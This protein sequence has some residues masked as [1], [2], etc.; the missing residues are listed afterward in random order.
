VSCG[1]EE[2]SWDRNA[3]WEGIPCAHGE[4][5][6]RRDNIGWRWKPCKRKICLSLLLLTAD[7]FLRK[8]L[9]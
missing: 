8:T 7:S 3:S 2:G 9:L 4:S 5:H 6:R 1:L